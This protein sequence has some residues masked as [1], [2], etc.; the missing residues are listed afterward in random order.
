MLLKLLVNFFKEISHGT[1]FS[2]FPLL[3]NKN[4]LQLKKKEAIRIEMTLKVIPFLQIKNELELKKK[5][6]ICIEITL[7]FIRKLITNCPF[8]ISTLALN[9]YK[10]RIDFIAIHGKRMLVATL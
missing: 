4:E 1:Y 7:K 3:Q 6:A 10:F 5:E 9:A 2:R 8:W